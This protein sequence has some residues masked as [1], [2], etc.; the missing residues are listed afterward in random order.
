MI[1]VLDQPTLG[2]SYRSKLLPGIGPNVH[3]PSG[4]G[5]TVGAATDENHL[6]NHSSAVSEENESSATPF[7]IA[8]RTAH[9]KPL[10]RGGLL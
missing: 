1:G 10:R 2:Y 8:R 5:K 6:E 9:L 3:H 4:Y 7:I